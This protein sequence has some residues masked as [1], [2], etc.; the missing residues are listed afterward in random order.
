MSRRSSKHDFRAIAAGRLRFLP[1]RLFMLTLYVLY[2]GKF[3]TLR[4]PSGYTELLMAQNLKP[5]DPLVTLTTD[6]YTARQYI[7]E[8]VGEQH[9]VPMHQ[10]VDS[11]DDLDFDAMPVPCVIKATH[12]YD[13]TIFVTDRD[14]INRSE[15]RETVRAWLKKDFYST[16][17]ERPYIGLT[18]RCVVEDF[19]GGGPDAPDDYKFFMFNGKLGFMQVHRDRQTNHRVWSFDVH[20][21]RLAIH[22]AYPTPEQGIAIPDN[23]GELIQLAETL[24]QDFECVRIDFY[25]VNGHAYVGELTHNP[26]ACIIRWHPDDF[27]VALGE[28][29]RNGTPIPEALFMQNNVEAL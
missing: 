20:G 7:A 10:V 16:W 18:S 1:R 13:M 14:A 9:L 17:K 6:K 21:N 24:S 28:F 5:L 29:W 25:V 23:Y 11:A 26:G 15:I 12:G 2:Q 8:K 3:T 27:D 22:G 19:L 4:R